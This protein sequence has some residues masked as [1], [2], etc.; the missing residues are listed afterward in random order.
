M[1]TY[2]EHILH[3]LVYRIALRFLLLAFGVCLL[4]GLGACGYLGH[5]KL[6]EKHSPVLSFYPTH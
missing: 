2:L 6:E 1:G 4:G 5:I 3:S